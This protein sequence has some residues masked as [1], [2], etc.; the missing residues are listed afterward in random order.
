[1]NLTIKR[2]FST[3]LALLIVSFF[4]IHV[5]AN[6]VTEL[7]GA[8][9]Y[10]DERINDNDLDFGIKHYTDIS[11]TSATEEQVKHMGIGVNEPFVPGKFY[12]QQVNVLEVPS[13]EDIRITPW[14]IVNQSSWSLMTVRAIISDYE[15]NNPGYKVIA[16]IN[17][18]FFD[19][20]AEKHFPRVPSGVHVSDGHFYKSSASRT[21][22]F[23][24]D[25][26]SKP[27]VGNESFTR[28]EKM[29]LAIYDN[30]DQIIFNY[31]IDHIN[32]EPGV[33][34]TSIFFANFLEH[35]PVPIEVSDGY[36]IEDAEYALPIAANDFYG[37]GTISKIG[38]ETLGEG[39]FALV[40]KDPLL[41]ERLALG[42][43]VRAQFEFSGEYA[44]IKDAVGAGE[45]LL[46]NGELKSTDTNRHPRTMI[47]MKED[48]TIIM[49]V[50]DGRQPDKNMYGASGAE[51]ATI[52]KHY[53]AVEGYNLDGG[54]S[55][56]MVIRKNG[57]FEVMNSPSD[58][59]ERSD[60]NGI[61]I[62]VK[63]PII[64]YELTDI[65]TSGFTVK[66]NIIDKNGFAIDKL[67]VGLDGENITEV[68]NGKAVFSNLN[69]NQN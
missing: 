11:Y 2:F 49:T 43:K 34:E 25:G 61:M 13:S 1:M 44:D 3:V 30:K 46:Y 52:L 10:I 28:T 55:S 27:L 63:V 37:L 9:Y 15:A 62:S 47:G 18:D 8:K 16:A 26:S 69:Q 20:R 67:Y 5:S 7:D 23:K 41:T 29:Q 48:G 50:V 51:M 60:A 68:V 21:I 59:G 12:P 24:N 36:I 42:I 33:G 4:T 6:E 14:A 53:G 22:G 58:G 17:G 56:T 40:S 66:P 35:L 31:E 64:D 19:I 38:E 57:L 65:T 32:A 54:G 39:Q 45:T